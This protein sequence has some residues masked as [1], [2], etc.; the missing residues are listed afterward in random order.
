MNN[1]IETAAADRAEALASE[2]VE[3]VTK[4]SVS[5]TVLNKRVVELTEAVTTLNAAIDRRPGHRPRFLNF[6]HRAPLRQQ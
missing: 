5:A 3:S 6:M 1:A 4:A 2:L